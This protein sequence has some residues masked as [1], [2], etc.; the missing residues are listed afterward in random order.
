M[1]EAPEQTATT[2]RQAF[3]TLLGKACL[4]VVA[5]LWGNLSP[6]WTRR[7][8][9]TF[10]FLAWPFTA[11]P[12]KII[13]ANLEIAFPE[14]TDKERKLLTT[15]NLQY[16]FELGLDWLHFF[17]HPQDIQ[18]RMVLTPEIES[19][20]KKRAED[21]SLPPGVFCTLHQGNW[22]LASRVSYLTGRRGAVITARFKNDWFNELAT[23]MR[24][25]G[26]D[27]EL[28]PVQ[29]AARGML[30]ALKEG[31]DLGILIDQHVSPRKGGIF[32]NFFGL[33]VTASPLP[34]TL[35][36]R[37]NLPV[38]VVACCKR[39]DGNFGFELEQLPK[40][41][42]Q[43]ASAAEL[44]Q[45]IFH[46]YERLIRRHP[47]QY[48]WLYRCWRAIPANATPEYRQRYPFY[49]HSYATFACETA[50]LT[51]GSTSKR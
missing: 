14:F 1:P 23:R 5:W 38:M 39:P 19:F 27:T 41:T 17:T 46:C 8:A 7:W 43:Y 37:A 25:E 26:T 28:L 50:L 44:T 13:R 16:I 48:L 21:S 45:D 4:P 10:Y 47:E 40:P 34:A 29:G 11:R 24:T 12:R 20:S 49:A 22:E 32:L 18:R 3:L 31:R 2:K 51:A 35:A 30:R 6:K 15:K 36:I 9:K 33:A 42:E